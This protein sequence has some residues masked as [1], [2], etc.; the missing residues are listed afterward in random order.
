MEEEFTRKD[1][2][3]DLM[4]EMDIIDNL[5][6]E[7]LGALRELSLSGLSMIG[8]NTLSKFQNLLIRF[9]I[10][11][12]ER[13]FRDFVIPARVVYKSQYLSRKAYTYGLEYGNLDETQA[14]TL[15]G[16][17]AELSLLDSDAYFED[18]F[19]EVEPS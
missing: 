7:R 5:K 8:G 12:N 1:H 18:I 3:S 6:N 13:L 9:S 19:N 17:I 11:D 16:L 4:V 14:K 2:R 15:Q 10:P